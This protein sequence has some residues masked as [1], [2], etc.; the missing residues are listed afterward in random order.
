MV[1][2]VHCRGYSLALAVSVLA[3][4]VAAFVAVDFAFAAAVVYSAGVD[5]F[6]FADPVDFDVVFVADTEEEVAVAAASMDGISVLELPPGQVV[7]D[8]AVVAVVVAAAD[9]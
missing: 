3:F 4:V 1:E 5:V 2:V 9:W 6:D 7:V 8:F